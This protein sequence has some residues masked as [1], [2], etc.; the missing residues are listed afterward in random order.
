LSLACY[1]VLDAD[2]PG[3]DPSVDGKAFAHDFERL[4]SLSGGALSGW[5]STDG[6]EEFVDEEIA[7]AEVWVDSAEAVNILKTL[8]EQVGDGDIADDLDDFL[9][10]LQQAAE[11]GARFH[12]ALDL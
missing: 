3:F 4:D 6:L 12:L 9:S 11:I 2:D 7:A 10:V 8:R 1:L 5:I